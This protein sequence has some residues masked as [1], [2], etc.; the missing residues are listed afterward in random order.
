[1]KFRKK[2]EQNVGKILAF[3][4]EF[5]KYDKMDKIVYTSVNTSFAQMILFKSP[6]QGFVIFGG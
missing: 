1:M 5:S 4:G 6:I 2:A 3:S